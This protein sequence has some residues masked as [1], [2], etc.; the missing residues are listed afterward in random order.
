MRYMALLA[1]LVLP[2][3]AW[4]GQD[5]KAWLDRMIRSMQSLNYEGTF[6]FMHGDRVDT[7]QIL[8]ERS[9]KGVSERLT[10][11]TGEAREL[12]RS[13][14]VLTCV[15]PHKDAVTVER[16]PAHNVFPSTIPTNTAALDEYYRFEFAG[17]ER[18]AG[19]TCRTIIVKPVD[20]LRYGHQLCIADNSGLLL[21]SV[22]F[23][24][25]GAPIEEVM[26]TSIRLHENIPDERFAPTMIKKD[27]IWHGAGIMQRS[28]KTSP[29]PNWRIEHVPPGF[30]ITG[31]IRRIMATSSQPVQHMILTDGLASV[32]VFIAKPQKRDSLFKGAVRSGA[33]N[34]FARSLNKF[35][36]TVVGEV[37]AATVKMIGKSIVYQPD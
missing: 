37:P 17:R 3:G 18:I 33:L 9:D 20:K 24:G 15:W 34:A 32:S 23:S 12:I 4:P 35:Q 11:L 36:I 30:K 5:A 16:M 6:V 13:E 27:H 7:M 14:G 29:D 25:D 26:F 31:S 21:R 28:I 19:M 22:L 10:S 2:Q 1:I 8:H